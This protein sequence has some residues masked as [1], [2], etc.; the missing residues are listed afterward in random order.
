MN[1]FGNNKMAAKI[2]STHGVPAELPLTETKKRVRMAI[3]LFYFFQGFCFASWASRIPYIKT[4]LGLTD[5]DMGNMLLALPLGQLATMPLSGFLVKKYGSKKILILGAVLYGIGL[6]NLGLAPN[7]YVLA[8]ALFLFGSFGNLANIAVNTQGVNGEK[9]YHRSIMA[10]FHGA[11]SLAGFTGALVGLIMSNLHIGPYPHF[12]V[13]A[14]MS[15]VSVV[16]NYNFLVED[17]APKH[18][19][20]RT[21]KKSRFKMPSGVILQLG[22]IGFFAMACEGAMFDWSGVYFKEIVHAPEGTETVGYACFM[23][24]MATGRFVGDRFITKLGRQ[25]LMQ[26]CGILIMSGLLLAVAFPYFYV[27]A[28]GFTMVGFGV[29]TNI[30]N[31]YSVAGTQKDISPSEALTAVSSIS[32]LGFL[33]GPPLIGYTSSLVNLRFS[34]TLIAVFGFVITLMVTKL[35]VIK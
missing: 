16:F 6:S 35:K 14:V 18:T 19:E 21:P 33:M 24:T 13:V 2:L 20:L 28:L 12:C 5:A 29:S 3:S 17:I 26:I 22:V 4:N 11:W 31:V 30:P 34:Y 27:A 23:V 25:K 32:F 15:I 1:I 7:K 9:M 10:S 8:A